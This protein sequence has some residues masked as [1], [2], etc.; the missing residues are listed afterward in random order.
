MTKLRQPIGLQLYTLGPE[1][2]QDLDRNLAAVAAIGFQEIELAGFLD[3]DPREVRRSL[4]QAGLKCPSVHI[5]ARGGPLSLEANPDRLADALNA[6]GAKTAVLPLP[7]IPDRPEFQTR[8]GEPRGIALRRVL[9][10][11][12]GDDWTAVAEFLNSRA[13]LLNTRGIAMAYHNHNVEFAPVDGT[14]GLD[15]LLARTDPSLVGFQLDTGWTVA[16]G[17]DPMDLIRR[18]P[19]RFTMMH[20]KD[21]KASTRANFILQQDP[22]EI[23][24]G[25]I[26]WPRLLPFAANAGIRHFFIEQD[27]PFERP[28]IDAVRNSFDSLTRLMS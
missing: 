28:R 15:I 5:P 13:K 4:D 1:V 10:L 26:D 3:R 18:H 25:V 6:V 23:G 9:P 22:A 27:P 19:H 7:L 2:A 16:A 11:L 21:V 14:T 20:V 12:T 24:T 17:L 8:S